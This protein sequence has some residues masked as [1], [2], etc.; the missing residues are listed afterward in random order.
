MC[1]AWP[2]PALLVLLTGC[3]G[4]GS[5][6]AARTQEGAA[7]V[8]LAAAQ[9]PN[10]PAQ[11][12][13]PLGTNVTSIA[14]GNVSSLIDPSLSS[15]DQQLAQQALLS[16]PPYWR[17]Q[18]VLI[19]D[20]AG[21]LHA[22]SRSLLETSLAAAQLHAGSPAPSGGYS[23]ASTASEALTPAAMVT[24][25]GGGSPVSISLGGYG[26]GPFRRVA[27]ECT[28]YTVQTINFNS[29][30][31]GTKSVD[32]VIAN[33]PTSSLDYIL[34]GAYSTSSTAGID[35]GFAYVEAGNKS[36]FEEIILVNGSPVYGSNLPCG[37]QYQIAL[38]LQA[39]NS[40]ATSEFILVSSYV[41]PVTGNGQSGT[42]VVKYVQ[43]S[44]YNSNGTNFIF[45]RLTSIAQNSENFSS[46]EWFGFA[47]NAN[48]GPNLQEPEIAYTGSTVSNSSGQYQITTAFAAAE[49]YPKVY[50]NVTGVLCSEDPAWQPVD[51]NAYEGMNLAN[52]N[53]SG[54]SM[55]GTNCYTGQGT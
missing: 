47:M 28:G 13:L 29:D 32:C 53:A 24:C 23:G 4:L 40:P 44:N 16:L 46:G 52:S 2:F 27:D 41:N 3:S 12:P 8:G 11:L 14:D 30:T 36:Y 15:S 54:G 1:K 26:T 45:R 9:G 22:S 19:V 43:S 48:G 35:A 17:S 42:P 31:T 7:R 55:Y 10:Q 21:N 34:G 18:G 6:F 20:E 50:N 51:F 39:A 33:A 38:S 5:E 25:P 49:R 37:G